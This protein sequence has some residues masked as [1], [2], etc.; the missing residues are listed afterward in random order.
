[1]GQT[2]EAFKKSMLGGAHLASAENPGFKVI[3]L[4]ELANMTPQNY[5]ARRTARRRQ[6]VDLGLVLALVRAERAPAVATGGAQALI[7]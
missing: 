3:G 7:T 2:A 5:Y 6:A 1:M 4:C